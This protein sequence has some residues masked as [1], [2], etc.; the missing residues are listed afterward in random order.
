MATGV[1]SGAWGYS[2]PT[3][4]G[5]L[6][7][8]ERSK[9]PLTYES[10]LTS[11]PPTFDNG[12][13]ISPLVVANKELYTRFGSSNTKKITKKMCSL[14]LESGKKINPLTGR[15]IKKN[16]VIYNELISKCIK[17]SLVKL[18]RKL[19]AVGSIFISKKPPVPEDIFEYSEK[20]IKGSIII[21]GHTFTKG[22][23]GKWNAAGDK[24]KIVAIGPRRIHLRDGSKEKR[25]SISS[26]I[27][28]NKS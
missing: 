10:P 7:R 2:I 12:R 28:Y 5:L 17:H 22:S 14:F 21:D 19:P 16:G 11:Y 9:H 23:L 1:L 18:P 13:F 25:I 6:S 20:S 24:K 3:V 27:E 4:A 8:V 26:F 15:S